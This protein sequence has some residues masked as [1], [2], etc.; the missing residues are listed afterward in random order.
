MH[1]LAAMGD[2]ILPPPKR[3]CVSVS[4]H[5]MKAEYNNLVFIIQEDS[6]EIG[7]YLYVY[8]N[9]KCTHDYV[10]DSIESCKDFTLEEF[11]VPKS[12]WQQNNQPKKSGG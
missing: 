9:G 10:Q 7:F 12:A 5:F 3:K 2:L 6:P 4:R 1:R 8:Q 11:N